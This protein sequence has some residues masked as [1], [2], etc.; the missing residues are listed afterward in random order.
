MSGKKL[1]ICWV[2]FVLFFAG[3]LHAAQLQHLSI[4]PIPSAKEL[5]FNL[6][7]SAVPQY[8]VFTLKNPHRLVLDFSET[9]IKVPLQQISLED[10]PISKIRHGLQSNKTQRLVF[11]LTSAAKVV[12][13]TPKQGGVGRRL[14]VMVKLPAW[15][16][17]SLAIEGKADPGRDVVVF[18][19]AGHGG[20][21]PGASGIHGAKEK[22]VVLAIAQKLYQSIQQEPGMHP[23]MSRSGNYYVTLR[24]RLN[25]ARH[26]KADIFVSIHADAFKHSHANGASVYALSLK[27]ATSEA[28]RWLANKENTSELGGVNLDGKGDVLRSVLLDL[29]Q[30]ATISD[31]LLFGDGVLHRLSK[32]CKLHHNQVEQAAFLV[33]KSPDI[34]SILVETGFIS[35]PVE[36]R[37]LQ[38]PMY[39]QKIAE[40]IT[41]GIKDYF[42][43]K[44]P[45]GTWVAMQKKQSKEYKVVAGDSLSSI[46]QYHH[47]SV[48]SLKQ[49]NGLGSNQIH[50]GQLLQ[51]PYHG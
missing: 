18:I 32:V 50:I 12:K 44:P 36:E 28:A 37:R 11:E 33:L 2:L 22:E 16:N 3:T 45:P 39:Q 25:L 19:D 6:E 30:T 4:Q 38:D 5:Q 43:Q 35:N 9:E 8:K 51:I 40:A 20:K 10:L 31:S 46:A 24:E 29:S 15:E 47:V 48:N 7:F 21:D 34:P 23:V 42:Y 26:N 41:S 49:Y 13:T 17:Q 1:S 27:G 14:V